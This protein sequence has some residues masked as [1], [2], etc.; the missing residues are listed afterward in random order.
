MITMLRN[1]PRRTRSRPRPS[2]LGAAAGQPASTDIGD[3]PAEATST[4]RAPR[5]FAA[6]QALLAPARPSTW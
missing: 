5:V 1:F 2:V 6:I 3:L 4:A